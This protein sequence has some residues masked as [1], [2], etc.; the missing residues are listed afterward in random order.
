MQAK[1]TTFTVSD[2]MTND[3]VTVLFKGHTF[4]FSKAP[5]TDWAN[6]QV[7]FPDGTK[8]SD[9]SLSYLKQLCREFVQCYDTDEQTRIAVQNHQTKAPQGWA[10]VDTSTEDTPAVAPTL[11]D[12]NATVYTLELE[13]SNGETA[14]K[15]YNDYRK[16]KAA[17]D[18]AV[19]QVQTDPRK[20]Y[21]R[22]IE[23]FSEAVG[24][25][26]KWVYEAPALAPKRVFIMT[27]R[28][29]PGHYRP[30]RIEARDGTEAG[31]Q[32]QAA[33]AKCGPGAWVTNWGRGGAMIDEARTTGSSPAFAAPYGT[34]M[35]RR[36]L[37][38][39]EALAVQQESLRVL[40]SNPRGIGHQLVELVLGD[41]AELERR[42]LHHVVKGRWSSQYPNPANLPKDGYYGKSAD[43]LAY[44]EVASVPWPCTR[45]PRK[46]KPYYRKERW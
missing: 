35:G 10:V 7:T 31:T 14:S 46:P 38:L 17:Y 37:T 41:F 5:A 23:L 18:L 19:E 28:I 40:R 8:Q 21:V 32:A 20:G 9:N 22:R 44:D 24:S 36:S 34:R 12:A 26:D 43:L 42:V 39:L 16:A 11:V 25:M 15:E 33:V 13:L 2:V 6:Y 3:V 27:V 45:K 30:V 29:K 1:L 4:T